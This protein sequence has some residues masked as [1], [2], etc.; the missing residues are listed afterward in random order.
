MKNLYF[1]AGRGQPEG[2]AVGTDWAGVVL[3]AI[4]LAPGGTTSK[5]QMKFRRKK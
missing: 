4:F 1:A 5:S 2:G 3:T